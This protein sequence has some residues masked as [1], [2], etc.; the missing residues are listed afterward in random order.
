MHDQLTGIHNIP[1]HYK[2]LTLHRFHYM[3]ISTVQKFIP[4]SIF[5]SDQRV[6]Q[7]NLDTSPSKPHSPFQI[8]VCVCVCVCI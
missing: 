3:Y 2:Y 1:G 8:A 6:L 7:D 4:G 5:L